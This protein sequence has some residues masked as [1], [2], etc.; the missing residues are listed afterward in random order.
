MRDALV[1]AKDSGRAKGEAKI[2]AL[3]LKADITMTKRG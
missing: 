1:K 3:D 2:S